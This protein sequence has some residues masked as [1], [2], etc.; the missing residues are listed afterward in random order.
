MHRFG[1]AIT[2]STHS[3]IGIKKCVIDYGHLSGVVNTSL[4]VSGVIMN[5]R[6]VLDV[7]STSKSF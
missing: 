7:P 3:Y 6:G 2:I 4:K 1:F 5:F